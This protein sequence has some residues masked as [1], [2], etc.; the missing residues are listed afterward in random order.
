MEDP[1]EVA[2][3][4]SDEALE[5]TNRLRSV[6]IEKGVREYIREIANEYRR[7][8]SGGSGAPEEGRS[9]ENS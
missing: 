3:Q 9:S 1:L 5:R 4:Q 2:Q 7:K 8:I 6:F